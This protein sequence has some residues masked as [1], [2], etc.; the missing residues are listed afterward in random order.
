MPERDGT[1]ALLPGEIASITLVPAAFNDQQQATRYTLIVTAK[2]EF[3]DL[4]ANKVLWSNPAMQFREE[5]EVTTVTRRR[6][7][8]R[9]SARTPTRSNASPRSC[10]RSIVS[11]MLE[12]F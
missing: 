1:D 3:R 2:I 10:A 11:A 12:A 8:P 5:Y 7:R 6:R 4:K 9:S